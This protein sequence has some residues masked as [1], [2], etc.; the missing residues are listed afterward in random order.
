MRWKQLYI[1]NTAN[2]K[3]IECS[4][5]YAIIL[6]GYDIITNLAVY[7][8]RLWLNKGESGKC[9]FVRLFMD[10]SDA[11]SRGGMGLVT[12]ETLVL[13]PTITR[14]SLPRLRRLLN[15]SVQKA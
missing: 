5:N 11:K 9:L 3:P 14:I 6:S 7:G 1:P 13:E 8:G 2:T 10:T 15:Q 12:W 4:P